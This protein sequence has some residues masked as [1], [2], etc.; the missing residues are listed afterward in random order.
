MLNLLLLFTLLMSAEMLIMQA[1][2][3][4]E[5]AISFFWLEVF[6][7]AALIAFI[8]VA[9][10]RF[11]I[12]T[13]RLTIRHDL[14]SESVLLRTGLIALTV[15]TM[16]M[17]IFPLI[18]VSATGFA[19][20]LSDGVIFSLI[21]TLL[22]H[23]L[24]LKPT[25]LVP[26]NQRTL[27]DKILALRGFLLFCYLSSLSLFLL[28]LLNVY[29]QQQQSYITQAVAAEKP[30][31]A[32]IKNSLNDHISK[33]ALD[34]L[35]LARQEN[36]QDLLSG[37]PEAR[38]RLTNDYLN[39]AAIKPVYEQI[40]Y[41]NAQGVEEIR[42]DQGSIDPVVIST[43]NLQDKHNRYYFKDSL[44][45]LAGQVYISPMDLNIEHKQIELP[46]K[47]IVRT[48]SPVFDRQGNKQGLVIINLNASALFTQLKGDAKNTA[49][50][51]MLLNEDGYWMFGRERDAAWAFMFPEY[52]DRTIEKYY[53]GIWQKIIGKD[54]GAFLSPYGYFIFDTIATGRATP[55]DPQHNKLAAE[56]HWPEWKLISLASPNSLSKAYSNF[57]PPLAMFFVLT[58]MVT[59]VG[60]I[61]YFRIQRK[62]LISQQQIEHL[63]HHDVLTGLNN[64]NIF[65]Q[66]LELQLTQ[67]RRTQ[68]PLALLYMDLDQFKPIND[69]YGHEAGDYVL[70]QFAARL[71]QILRESDLLA[72]LGGDEFAALLSSYGN[73]RQLEIIAERIISATEEPVSFRGQQLQV[74]ISIGIA[75]HF[76]GLPLESLLH[77][78]DQ[79]MYKAKRMQSNSYCFAEAP[80]EH[81]KVQITS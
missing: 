79:A 56:L 45:L 15:E 58:A 48:A 19:V 30:Q 74:G 44:K 51:L 57:L 77:E 61:M 3:R 23:Y 59:G 1:M 24:L 50:E 4:L 5:I 28:L 78:A 62:N 20:T 32:L 6:L 63:A 64:R 34:T 76:Q 29:Q 35:M 37:D 7:D 12:K 47:P 66:I 25:N 42:V 39:L 16:L 75:L 65:I 68:E 67:S 80:E 70:K 8:T 22:I 11:F 55:E 10:V 13:N 38:T 41:L 60:T 18:R 33:A 27:I 36:L 53:P 71:K 81:Q 54:R 49:G 73:K 46:F 43:E 21:T 17:L 72:R 2:Q 40:R 69:R 31:L 52:K 9:I 14:N 26:V